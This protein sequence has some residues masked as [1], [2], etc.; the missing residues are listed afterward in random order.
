M[1]F[2]IVLNKVGL[3]GLNIYNSQSNFQ[4]KGHL[5]VN[6][7]EFEINMDDAIFKGKCRK[8]QNEFID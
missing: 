4:F 1:T 6:W 2:E 8:N 3:I 5:K 7:K